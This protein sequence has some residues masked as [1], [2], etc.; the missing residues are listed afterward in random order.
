MDKTIKL[1]EQVI[2]NGPYSE[3]APLAQLN[4][5]AAYE[6]KF[7]TD[8]PEAARSYER[9]AD[10]YADRKEGVD[11]LYRAA[12][13][14]FKQAKKAEYDQSIAAQSIATFTDFS[15]LHPTDK[16][17]PE[18]QRK[19]DTLKTEQARGSYEI[20]RYYERR[21]KW[22]GARIYYND[23]VAKDPNSPFA[24]ES[25]QRIDAITR[26]I[27]GQPQPQSQPAPTTPPQSQPPA[28]VSPPLSK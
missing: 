1:Y 22:E 20:A 27:Q 5:G 14:Y 4:I 24:E 28:S 13:T 11:A 6:R 25:R 21:H 15:T 19:I 8:Y 16:R 17:V 23:V 12:D 7:V 26:Q 3:V 2:K 18:A 10:K 9:A